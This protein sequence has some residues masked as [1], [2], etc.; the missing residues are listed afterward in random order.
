MY[1]P[2]AAAPAAM[3]QRASYVNAALYHYA[4]APYM[5]RRNAA[6]RSMV[7]ACTAAGFSMAATQ[8]WLNRQGANAL[9]GLPITWPS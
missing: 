6:A 7:A 1:A 3:P 4:P 2:T 9:R 5:R 8:G